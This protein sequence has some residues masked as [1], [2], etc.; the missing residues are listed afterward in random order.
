MNDFKD[1]LNE[2]DAE[3]RKRSMAHKRE[4]RFCGSKKPKF[5]TFDEW[6]ALDYKVI[7]GQKAHHIGPHGALFEKCQVEDSEGNALSPTPD[8]KGAWD[9]RRDGF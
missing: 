9:W 4:C 6:K 8:H 3:D 1:L 7:R 2:I 5:N